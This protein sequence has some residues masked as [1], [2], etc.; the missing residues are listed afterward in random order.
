MGVM[1]D[2]SQVLEVSPK[3]RETRTKFVGKLIKSPYVMPTETREELKTTLP[4]PEI[5]NP[6]RPI[7]PEVEAKFDA[8]I[9]STDDE[10]IDL[11]EVL[12][13]KSFFLTLLIDEAWLSDKVNNY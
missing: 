8:Y 5:F 6:K 11:R 13:D 1:E 3:Q 10:P 12:A 4:F 9:A 2:D 7:P